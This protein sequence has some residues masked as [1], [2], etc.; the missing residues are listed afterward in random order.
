ADLSTL[1]IHAFH[2][3]WATQRVLDEGIPAAHRDGL[4]RGETALLAADGSE[5]PVSQLIL[6]H[7]NQQGQ[8]THLSTVAHDLRPLKQSQAEHE[9]LQSRLRDT[10]R[11]E[12]IGTLAGGVAHD[13]NNVL[14][15]ILGNVAM[16]RQDVASEHPVQRPLALV[17]QAAVRAR[18]LVQQILTFSRRTP[19]QRR[20]QPLQALV[21]EA[22]ALLRATLPSEV[23]LDTA[24]LPT[25]LTVL[26]DGAQMQ[27]V[28]M[29]LCTNAWQ[30]LPEQQ[31]LIT[32][33]VDAVA[34]PAG[35]AMAETPARTRVARLQVQDSG[36][37]M[38]AATLAHIF[39]PFFTTKPVGQG[40]GLGLAVV[41]GIVTGSGGAIVVD[42]QPGQGSCFSVYLPLC[43][44]PA[45]SEPGPELHAVPRGHGERLL[46]VDDDEVVGLTMQS[47][48]E[49][50]GYQVTRLTDGH[51]AVAAVQADPAG[52]ALLITDFNMPGLSGL[53]VAKAVR[54]LA[55]GLPLVITSGFVDEALQLRAQQAGVDAVLLKEHS[56]ER[57]PAL[58]HALLARRLRPHNAGTALAD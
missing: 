52:H 4:W 40:T 39:E 42:S 2:P 19:Q 46:Y 38:D 29:N 12:A 22:V 57:L 13:F 9:A 30:A 14:A 48:L 51:A 54:A 1:T 50:A 31:G 41:H 15:A 49:R 53:A 55:P 35:V 18:T 34:L 24:L 33:R 47:L 26:T 16:A 44:E 5:V 3:P 56:M 10:Q 45:A 6:C 7:R 20:P 43:A 28:V 32:V 17:Q 23:R 27:Q 25:P 36:S 8:V 11:L 21:A 37:G 58:V